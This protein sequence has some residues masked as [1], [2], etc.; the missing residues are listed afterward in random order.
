MNCT[1]LAA[2]PRFL[3]FLPALFQT[4]A[5]FLSCLSSQGDRWNLR[6]FL[7]RRL[8]IQSCYDVWVLKM[9]HFRKAELVHLRLFHIKPVFFSIF[10]VF[11]CVVCFPEPFPGIPTEL[12]SCLSWRPHS[13]HVFRVCFTVRSLLPILGPALFPSLR[14]VSPLLQKAGISQQSAPCKHWAL[15]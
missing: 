1:F 12:G 13:L 3:K 10:V 4:A 14:L 9:P 11:I 6:G 2:R 8:R 15:T 7:F 5:W